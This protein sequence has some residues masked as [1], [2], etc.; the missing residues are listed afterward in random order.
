MHHRVP[1]EKIVALDQLLENFPHFI[2][3][4]FSSQ[5]HRNFSEPDE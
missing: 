3:T 1:F 4:E 2:E 5:E